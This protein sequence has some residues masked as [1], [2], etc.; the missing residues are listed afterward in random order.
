ME[1]KWK[2]MEME[3]QHLISTDILATPLTETITDDLN[4]NVTDNNVTPDH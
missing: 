1:K 2:E 3:K 4:K